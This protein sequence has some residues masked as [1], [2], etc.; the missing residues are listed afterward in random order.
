MGKNDRPTG[1]R[2]FKP[3]ELRSNELFFDEISLVLMG[4]WIMQDTPV[5][6]IRGRGNLWCGQYQALISSC[7]MHPAFGPLSGP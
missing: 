5:I 3:I 4:G 7:R 1:N 6:D 2:N